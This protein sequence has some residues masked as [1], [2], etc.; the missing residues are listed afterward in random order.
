MTTDRPTELS[1]LERL[2]GTPARPSQPLCDEVQYRAA[3]LRWYAFGAIARAR[4]VVQHLIA[5]YATKGQIASVE[6]IRREDKLLNEAEARWEAFC[7]GQ[8]QEDYLER[9][10]TAGLG[11]E[12][13][14]HESVQEIDEWARSLFS[15]FDFR[16]FYTIYNEAALDG[17]C[18]IPLGD[19]LKIIQAAQCDGSENSDEWDAYVAATS[20]WTGKFTTYKQFRGLLDKTSIRRKHRGMH[21]Y[22][23]ARDWIEHWRD[24]DEKRF[25]AMEAISAAGADLIGDERERREALQQKKRKKE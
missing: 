23:H 6:A 14:C 13:P 7:T 2:S 20:V 25:E 19:P 17:V 9:F 12:T 22:I 5:R 24:K 18:D 4:H 3:A 1:L 16:Y 11:P 8:F 10:Q 15:D 21:L